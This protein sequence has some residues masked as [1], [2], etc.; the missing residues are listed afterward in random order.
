MGASVSRACLVERKQRKPGGFLCGKESSSQVTPNTNTYKSSCFEDECPLLFP[1]ICPL[2]PYPPV[3]SFAS[4][5]CFFHSLCRAVCLFLACLLSA[6]AARVFRRLWA[7]PSLLCSS[8]RS[9]S[10]S[11]T[12]SRLAALMSSYDAP[13][14]TPDIE[15]PEEEREGGGEEVVMR[16]WERERERERSEGSE[17]G[18]GSVFCLAGWICLYGELPV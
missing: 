2:Q 6:V 11:R 18:E 15:K 17:E 9:F 13:G 7:S 14:S 4:S 8:C 10:S 3:S 5:A 16:W 1:L 12:S